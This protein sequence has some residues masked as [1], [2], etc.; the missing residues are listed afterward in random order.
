[1]NTIRKLITWLYINVCNPETAVVHRVP[2]DAFERASATLSPRRPADA[3]DSAFQAGIAY[4]L[5]I[6]RKELTR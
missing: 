1:M 4:S 2:V 5:S 3:N 6:L